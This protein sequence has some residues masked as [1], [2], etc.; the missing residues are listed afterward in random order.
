MFLLMLRRLGLFKA[1]IILDTDDWEGEGGFYTQFLSRRLYP[2]YQLEFYRFQNNWVPKH[3]DA[4]T[5]A[6]RT[7]QSLISEMGV[8]SSRI[9]YLPNGTYGLEPPPVTE[10]QA[11][12][13]KEKL[14]IS[15]KPVV[16]LYTRFFE[17]GVKQVADILQIL[18]KEVPDTRLLVVGKGKFGEENDLLNLVKEMGI[19]DMVTF[20]GWIDADKVHEY[21]R[22][23]DV[24]I[25]PFDDNLLNRTKC[26]GKLVEMMNLGICVIANKVGQIAEYIEDGKSGI[27]VEPGDTQGF[28]DGIIRL[29]KDERLRNE[30]GANARKMIRT[31]FNWEKLLAVLEDVYRNK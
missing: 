16:L 1:V 27:L 6:S 5:A 24:A 11:A 21:L 28:A 15:G 12:I 22:V 20:T 3:V 29:L 14:S 18:Q 30:I 17:F 13:L 26:P 31:N 7:L 2:R 4:V 19:P 23:S 25:Y 8:P 9:Y 10:S